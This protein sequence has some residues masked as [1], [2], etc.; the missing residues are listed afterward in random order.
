MYGS[1]FGT[2]GGFSLSRP[3]GRPDVRAV[4]GLGDLLF[5]EGRREVA[6]GLV[7]EGVPVADR[8]AIGVEAAVLLAHGARADARSADGAV[9]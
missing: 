4:D 6:H 1:S 7:A 5:G 2:D 9:S 3:A 8:D